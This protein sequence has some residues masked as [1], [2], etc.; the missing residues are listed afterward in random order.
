M[1][2]N[3]HRAEFCIDKLYS[4]DSAAGRLGLLELRAFE[5][6]PHARMSLAQQLL[7]RALVAWF[8]REP[9][10][11]RLARYG[12]RLHDEFMLPHFVAQDFADV[13]DDVRRAGYGFAPDWFAPHHEF[14]FPLI[15]KVAYRGIEIELR[16]ALEPWHVLGEE[17]GSGGTARFVDSSV[18]RLQ[19]KLAGAVGER[20]RLLVQ[21]QGQ[22]RCA[23]TGRKGEYVAGVRFRAWQP[24]RA[25]HP[26]IPAD[27][28]LVFDLYDIGT[29]A[30]SAAAPITSPIPAAATSRPSR[31]TPTR[32][33]PGAAPASSPSAT[34]PARCTRSR[35]RPAAST[36]SPSTSAARSERRQSN[37]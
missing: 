37:E 29:S 6:P 13:L 27:A 20:H 19:V 24:P 14:R 3:T 21:R 16:H 36:P 25:L 28:P 4:P 22:C 23:P 34:P 5:M 7:L 8:W 33:R 10:D 11:K 18:E 12:T 17:A 2:G 32:P 35:W 15:G 26:T 30:R 31:S 1:T 9:Y